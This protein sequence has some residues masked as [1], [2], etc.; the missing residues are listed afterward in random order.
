[1]IIA[2]YI[3]INVQRQTKHKVNIY[4]RMRFQT[5]IQSEPTA[6][7]EICVVMEWVH[8]CVIC[9]MGLLQAMDLRMWSYQIVGKNYLSRASDS[10]IICGAMSYNILIVE[11]ANDFKCRGDK[12]SY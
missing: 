3:N 8:S 6:H 4:C 7:L 2:L 11:R 12:S 9:I 10:F 5:Y 1:M